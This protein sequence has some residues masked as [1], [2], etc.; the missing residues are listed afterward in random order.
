MI[1]GKIGTT[2]LGWGVGAYVTK[3][4]HSAQSEK[5]IWSWHGIGTFMVKAL[6]WRLNLT[7]PK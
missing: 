1:D 7:S 6:T 3:I 5:I 2:A 4:E